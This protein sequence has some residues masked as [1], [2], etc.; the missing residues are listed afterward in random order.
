MLMKR[1]RIAAITL[2]GVGL[3]ACSGL[4]DLTDLEVTNENAPDRERVLAQAQD[5]EGVIGGAMLIYW[6]GSEYTSPSW[7]LST[8]ADE[9]TM[10]WG[11]FGMQQLSSE[12]RVAWPNDPAW[13]YRATTQEPWYENYG[14]LS[15]V[16][17]G[18]TGID[19]NADAATTIDVNRAKAF[20]KL[21]QGLAHGYLAAFFDSAFVF[22]ETVNLET[23]L[24]ELK[25]YPDVHAAAIA[26]LE[27]AISIASSNSFTIPNEWFDGNAMTNTQ[28][29][30]FAH[31]IIARLMTQVART[32]ADR[33]AVDW[34]TVIGHVNAGITSDINIVSNRDRFW[35]ALQWYGY[36]TTNNTWA[37]G[38][39]KT[40][41][42]TDQSGGFANWLATPVAQRNEFLIT[43]AD[44]RITGAGGPQTNGTDFRYAGPSTFPSARGTYHYSYYGGSRFG[45]Y[46][47]SNGTAPA[48]W[49]TT[50]E[51]Q[52]IKAE[53]LLRTGGAAALPEVVSIINATRVTRGQLP[54]ATVADA[55]LMDKLI[56][57]KRI[58]TYLLCSGCS[59]FDRRGFGPTAPTGPAFHHGPVEGTPTHFAV[60]GL[61][62][63]V[64]Q[65]PLYT[66]GG[67]GNE[68]SSLQPSGA[69]GIGGGSIGTRA[70][71]SLVYRPASQRG[72]ASEF[73]PGALAL[74]GQRYY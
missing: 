60:P 14:A 13:T 42:W 68:G 12:P 2:L 53:G 3:A 45:N 19:A 65:K 28:L 66:Y 11:N 32:P 44:R 16:Y 10:S 20:A 29:A 31:S 70:P 63:N 22:D 41:G 4:S 39:Y 52:L 64:L 40:I 17:D 62:L 1:F 21:V 67:V 57:E 47:S 43:T 56:Y 25:P 59:Y 50:V 49:M 73:S 34:A 9:G 37:R 30:R 69:P 51:M 48:R 35:K 18:I 72:T 24:L 15:A 27:E 38:D 74:A 6:G 61:E 36:Q 33:A 7:A 8:T 26:E 23:D 5:L 71:A 58:E 46:P 54:A 55:D